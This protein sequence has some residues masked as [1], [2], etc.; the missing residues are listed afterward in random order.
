MKRR[1]GWQVTPRRTYARPFFS[2]RL[3]RAAEE[4]WW[5]GMEPGGAKERMATGSQNRPLPR[6]R[7]GD[8]TGCNPQK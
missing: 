6:Q 2:L 1:E 3:F 8:W 5:F 7:A 4:K